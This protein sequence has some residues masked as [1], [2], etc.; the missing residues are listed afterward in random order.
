MKDKGR[1]P[2]CSVPLRYSGHELAAHCWSKAAWLLCCILQCIFSSFLLVQVLSCSYSDHTRGA[3]F[4]SNNFLCW[5]CSGN[6]GLVFDYHKKGGEKDGSLGFI[7]MNLKYGG[8]FWL[9]IFFWNSSWGAARGRRAM[10]AIRVGSWSGAGNHTGIHV[11]WCSVSALSTS[12]QSSENQYF[13]WEALR[14]S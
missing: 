6:S 9:G 13:L 14:E 8:V 11:S 4:C 12:S 5:L 3:I 10:A 2:L 1:S 7:W